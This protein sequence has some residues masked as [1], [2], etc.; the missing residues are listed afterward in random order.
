MSAEV[1][2]LPFDGDVRNMRKEPW[3]E[4][5]LFLTRCEIKIGEEWADVK[6]TDDGTSVSLFPDGTR[7]IKGADGSITT[8]H[9]NGDMTCAREDGSIDFYPAESLDNLTAKL[10]QQIRE[11]NADGGGTIEIW[12]DNF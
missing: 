6:V 11:L 12:P 4:T 8:L 2:R 9:S 1:P 10:E 7:I 3:S 5:G